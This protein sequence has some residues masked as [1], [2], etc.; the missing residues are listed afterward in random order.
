M[1]EFVFL[2]RRE[3]EPR[4]PEQARE[5]MKRW[6][7]WFSDLEK[8]GHLLSLGQPLEMTSGAVVKDKKGSFSAGPY[9]ETTD[10]VG[11]FSVIQANDLNEAVKLST[12][13]PIFDFGGIVE[14]RP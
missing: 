13:C 9:V 8:K 2:Y 7:A 12:G 4:S 6:S 14:V 1:N 10:I 11:G 5:Q 3:M